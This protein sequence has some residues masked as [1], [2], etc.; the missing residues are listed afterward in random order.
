[1]EHYFEAVNHFTWLNTNEVTI[2][3]KIRASPKVESEG[4]RGPDCRVSGEN[5]NSTTIFHLF[6]SN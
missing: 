1:M 2:T 3:I 4:R 5:P 6:L